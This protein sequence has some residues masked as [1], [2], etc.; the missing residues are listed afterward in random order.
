MPISTVSQHLITAGVT[1]LRGLCPSMSIGRA[2]SKTSHVPT[3]MQNAIESFSNSLISRTN[4][5]HFH[6]FLKEDW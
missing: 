5:N 3:Q 4:S 1:V 2:T 6:K